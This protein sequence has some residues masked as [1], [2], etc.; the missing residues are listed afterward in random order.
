[1]ANEEKGV[2]HKNIKFSDR[3]YLVNQIDDLL[4]LKQDKLVAGTGVKI[5][6]N[7]ISISQLPKQETNCLHTCV[8]FDSAA[9]NVLEFDKDHTWYKINVIDSTGS[10]PLTLAGVLTS[11]SL[12][13]LTMVEVVLLVTMSSSLASVSFSARYPITYVGD[14][15]FSVST[16]YQTMY[17]A[18][19]SFN[20]N[21]TISKLGVF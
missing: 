2:L 8:L 19:R 1:M 16:P 18:I 20:N 15:N 3:V 7:V 12:S 13:P 4:S 14:T 10:V 5:E 11:D 17:I 21:I 9:N 6:G